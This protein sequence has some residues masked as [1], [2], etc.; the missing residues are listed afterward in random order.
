MRLALAAGCGLGLS[1]GWNTANVGAVA[2]P[3]ARAYGV[4]LPV[5]GLF[6]TAF[7]VT[8]L[9]L[10]IP[11]G[12]A[13][14]R[15][16]AR[17]SGLVALAVIAAANTLALAA[18]EPALAFATRALTGVGTGLAFVAG[19][20]YIRRSGGSPFAQGLF[21]GI[22]LAG[23]G[24]ALAIVPQVEDV[25][26][27]RAPFLGSV[28]VSGLGLAL[29]ALAPADRAPGVVPAHEAE[30][31]TALLR[32][33]RLYRLA[34]LYAASLG[35]SLTA[36]NW[37]VTLLDRNGGVSGGT[38]GVVG[39][40]TFLLGVISRPLGGWLVREHPRRVRSS[41]A[42][43]LAAGGAGTAA[44]TVAEPLPLAVVG[45]I[46]VGFAGGIPFAPAF[47]GAA[48]ARPDQPAAAVGFVNGAASV[49]VIAGTPLL[50]LTFSLP[51]DGRIGFAVVAALWAAALLVL[52]TERE[53]GL[54]PT[55][56]H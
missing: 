27:W 21:G 43:S 35:L 49:V 1:A 50:G 47:T 20:A 5:V 6:T 28:A 7:F 3:L 10:Q 53:L 33:R 19:I 36:G 15:F 44:L 26:D 4:G 45:A 39:G 40:L 42:L 8:H 31:P 55:E 24:V 38:A 41:V 11:G 54:A 13:S 52:P 14:D 9:L 29:L 18:P 48:S 46:L 22:G 30:L 17:R 37:V 16:G 56:A 12:R 34:A 2:E 32:D 23:A 51:G 25:F